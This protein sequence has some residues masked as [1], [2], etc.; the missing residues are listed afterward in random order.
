MPAI[1]QAANRAVNLFNA[2]HHKDPKAF[3]NQFLAPGDLQ[4]WPFLNV[5]PGAVIVKDSAKLIAMHDHW[6]ASSETG[7]KPYHD[8]I[9]QDREFVTAD[10]LYCES[11]AGDN[12]VVRCGAN[13]HVMKEKNLGESS[14]EIVTTPMHLS[15]IFAFD[16]ETDNWW[17]T[18]IN[19]TTLA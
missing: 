10:L 13:A 9:G 11:I 3:T 17:V 14:H 2:L 6:F 19:N 1:E 5:L 4:R 16:L 18:Q 12:K 8:G 15:L 7:F